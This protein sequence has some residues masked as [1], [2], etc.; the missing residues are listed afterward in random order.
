MVGNTKKEDNKIKIHE[1]KNKV[2]SIK[3]R[4]AARYYEINPE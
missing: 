3:I 1:I 4:N 2:R